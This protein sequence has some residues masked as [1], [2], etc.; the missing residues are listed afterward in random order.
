MVYGQTRPQLW[1]MQ[2]VEPLVS[3]LLEDVHGEYL[4]LL[5]EYSGQR[6]IKRLRQKPCV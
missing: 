6:V 4:Q 2:Q 1:A 5:S 3:D